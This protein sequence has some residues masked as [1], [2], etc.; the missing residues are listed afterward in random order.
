MERKT[1]VPDASSSEVFFINAAV[2][3][4]INAETA[5]LQLTCKL[6]SAPPISIPIVTINSFRLFFMCVLHFKY[7]MP[8]AGNTSKSDFRQ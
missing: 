5:P 8:M 2:G 6:V 4:N 3:R 1:V 7:G